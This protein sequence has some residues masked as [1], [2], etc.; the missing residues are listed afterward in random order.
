M[1]TLGYLSTNYSPVA[2]TSRFGSGRVRW[3]MWVESNLVLQAN[4]GAFRGFG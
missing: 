2:Q 3:A 4:S 1:L